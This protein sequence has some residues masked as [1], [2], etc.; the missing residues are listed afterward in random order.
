[1][2]REQILDLSWSRDSLLAS[3]SVDHTVRLWHFESQQALRVFNH[4]PPSGRSV[5]G[6]RV[7]DERGGLTTREEGWSLGKNVSQADTKGVVTG[8]CEESTCCFCSLVYFSA[9]NLRGWRDVSGWFIRREVH[10]LP[11]PDERHESE[12]LSAVSESTKGKNSRGHKITGLQIASSSPDFSPR[13]YFGKGKKHD[14]NA[15]L[16]VTTVDSRLFPLRCLVLLLAPSQFPP[17]SSLSCNNSYALMSRIRLYRAQD[18][19]LLCKYRGGKLTGEVR[20]EEECK[21]ISTGIEGV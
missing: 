17:A 10:F 8:E 14:S 4:K 20:D 16:L 11:C 5:K 7:D 9:G 12:S 1:M 13:R 19:M 15:K 18:M 6:L 21:D 2:T 3:A